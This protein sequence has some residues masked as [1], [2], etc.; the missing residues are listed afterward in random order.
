MISTGLTKF[1]QSKKKKYPCHVNRISQL[2]EP[3][4]RKLYYNR[5]A[6]DKATDVEDSLQG[7][8]ETGNVLE[9]V[10]E[11]IVSEIGQLSEPQFRIVGTQTATD[12][13]LLKEYQISGTIDG[14]LQ[15]KENDRWQTKGVVDIKTMSPNI[16]PA[17]NSYDDLLRYPWTA[18]YR[19]QLMLYALAHNIDHCY[20]LCVNKTNLYQMKFIDFDLEMEYCDRLLAKAKKV[21]EAIKADKPPEGINDPDQCP[22]C[23]FFSHC[24]PDIET[25]GNLQVSDNTELEGIFERLAEL[26]PAAKQYKN[27]KKSRDNIL[28]KGQDIA[29]GRWLVTWR[30]TTAHYKAKEAYR[31]DIWRKKI[32]SA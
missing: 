13:D 23:K 6:W 18:K 17:I 16:Y 24:C 29:I 8:F 1:L 22:K 5:T 9:P 21:N 28:I 15:I 7:I 25:K 2:D 12:D 4:L 32:E 3:C 30:K 31:K 10:I 19:G 27:L 11:R 26:E 14:F 20:I